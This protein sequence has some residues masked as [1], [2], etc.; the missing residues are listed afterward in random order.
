MLRDGRIV[1]LATIAAYGLLL[2][3]ERAGAE[4]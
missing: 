4:G 1:D 3:E 2:L